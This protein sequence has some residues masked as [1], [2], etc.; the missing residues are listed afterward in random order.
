MLQQSFHMDASK[1]THNR[2]S[3]LQRN[4]LSFIILRIEQMEIGIFFKICTILKYSHRQWGPLQS[5]NALIS[6]FQL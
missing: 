5:K 6:K 1:E 3:G 4:N 2:T